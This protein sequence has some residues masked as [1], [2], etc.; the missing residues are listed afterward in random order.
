MLPGQLEKAM[1]I[2]YARGKQPDPTRSDEVIGQSSAIGQDFVLGAHK[3]RTH[4]HGEVLQSADHSPPLWASVGC[5]V[6]T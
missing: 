4:G 5:F 2:V 3:M 1:K 6:A